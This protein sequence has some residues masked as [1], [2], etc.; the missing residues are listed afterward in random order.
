MAWNETASP[1]KTLESQGKE[2]E[3]YSVKRKALKEV[4]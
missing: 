4:K 1:L 3:L 2:L